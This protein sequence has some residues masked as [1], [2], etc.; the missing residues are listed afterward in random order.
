MKNR[1]YL[2]MYFLGCMLCVV[3]LGACTSW[4]GED[5]YFAARQ[6]AYLMSRNGNPLV[7]PSGLSDSTIQ[8][9]Y[10]L[11]SVGGTP[12]VSL[13]PPNFQ[14]KKQS[15]HVPYMPAI[16]ARDLVL[17]KLEKHPALLLAYPIQQAWLAVDSGLRRKHMVVLRRDYATKVYTMRG[18]TR[19]EIHLTPKTANSTWITLARV[20][21]TTAREILSQLNDGMQDQ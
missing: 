18:P 10:D 6:N 3:L 11:A 2:F 14:S 17:S 15:T 16:D 9:D 7:V 13:L 1:M 12:G 19:Y 21:D 8:H 4:M 20:N 5:N